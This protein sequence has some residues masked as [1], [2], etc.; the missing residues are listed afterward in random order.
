MA[1]A[2]QRN[3]GFNAYKK[4]FRNNVIPPQALS[5]A[6]YKYC[7]DEFL[8]RVIGQAPGG[9]AATGTAG[10]INQFVTGSVFAYPVEMFVIGTQTIVLPINSTAGLNV[11]LDQTSTD[12]AEYIFG[13]THDGLAKGRFGFTSQTDKPFFMRM[14]LSIADASGTDA[15]YFGWKKAT[16]ANA[17]WATGA[18][19]YA[20]FA[21]LTAADP[22]VI[23]TTTR[24]NSGTATTTTTSATWADAA[25]KTLEVR[26]DGRGYATFLLG[27]ASVGG[28]VGF[29]FDSGDVLVPIFRYTNS[30][31]VAGDIILKSLEIGYQ[32]RS[33]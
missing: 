24:L 21:I 31:D 20:C 32:D 3:S 12:G 30:A 10:D 16:A 19:D 6:N 27:G 2:A 8:Y 4:N 26:V 17:T 7:Y 23:K 18:T 11:A 1:R 29:R 28:E 15:L 5:S 22:A 14:K 33:Y 25:T 9:G 13:A